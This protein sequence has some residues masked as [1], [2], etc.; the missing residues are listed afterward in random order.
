MGRDVQCG[1]KCVRAD[2]GRG[3]EV[4]AWEDRMF[5]LA[6]PYYVMSY[7]KANAY[8]TCSNGE[9]TEC[10]GVNHVCNRKRL[11]WK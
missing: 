2:L 6:H 3:L 1:H 4:V 9:D 11:E 5:L 7:L 10:V 8:W